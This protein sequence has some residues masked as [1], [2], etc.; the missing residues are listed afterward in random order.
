MYAPIC[1]HTGGH[2]PSQGGGGGGGGAKCPP[3]P[4]LK[5]PWYTVNAITSTLEYSSISFERP[6]SWETTTFVRPALLGTNAHMSHTIFSLIR[7]HLFWETTFHLS[8]RVVSQKGYYCISTYVLPYSHMYRHPYSHMYRHP[9][10]HMYRHPY[11]HM[12]RHP[13]S[14]MYRHPYSHMYRHPYHTI[15]TNITYIRMRIQTVYMY[16]HTCVILYIHVWYHT[17]VHVQYYIYIR[18]YM[19]DTIHTVCLH[20]MHIL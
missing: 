8:L 14:H 11:S 13:Y 20:S 7:D 3:C 1:S 19:Y 5:K 17:Y 12:Y 2:D 15:S 10:S 6:P 18:T 4:P 9:Y 16:T